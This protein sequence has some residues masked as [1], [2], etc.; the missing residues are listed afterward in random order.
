MVVL[1]VTESVPSVVEETVRLVNEPESPDTVVP[2]KEEPLIGVPVMVPPV[3]ATPLNLSMM[4][5]SAMLFAMPPDAGGVAY[6]V[7]VPTV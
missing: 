3:M 7:G 4:F 1:P 6:G 2:E 5:K